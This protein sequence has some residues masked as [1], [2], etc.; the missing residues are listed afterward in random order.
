MPLP[1]DRCQ[2]VLHLSLFLFCFSLFCSL[3]FHFMFFKLY[4]IVYCITVVPVSP[5]CPLYPFPSPP[6]A[7]GNASTIAHVHRPFVYVLWLLYSRC[8][9]LHL[10]YY[11]VTTNLSFLITSPFS[12]PLPSGNIQNILCI[13]DSV[14]VLLILLKRVEWIWSYWICSGEKQQFEVCSKTLSWSQWVDWEETI[15]AAGKTCVFSWKHLGLTGN[16]NRWDWE[17]NWALRPNQQRY[18]KETKKGVVEARI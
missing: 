7:S 18:F 17:R 9:T 13:Y 2:S 3:D 6:T 15:G 5:L 10:H 14:S 12:P 8:C 1:S 16:T 11:P 4:F